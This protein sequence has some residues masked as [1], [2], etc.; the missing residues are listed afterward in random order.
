LVRSRLCVRCEYPC[1]RIPPIATL[2]AS[3]SADRALSRYA[4]SNRFASRPIRATIACALANH[5]GTITDH[6]LSTDHLKN[7]YNGSDAGRAN[8]DTN[9][10]R[11]PYAEASILSPSSPLPQTMASKEGAPRASRLSG[12]KAR[13]LCPPPGSSKTLSDRA[14]KDRCTMEISKCP[15]NGH[16]RELACIITA[17]QT[18]LYLNLFVTFDGD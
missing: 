9:G 14:T 4:P 12:Q 18:I 3:A 13:L 6:R 15:I 2:G 11:N 16:L 17:R 1:P 7:S 8:N 10:R 5:F